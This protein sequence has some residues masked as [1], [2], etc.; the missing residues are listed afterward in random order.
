MMLLAPSDIHFVRDC[1]CPNFSGGSQVVI[2]VEI[3]KMQVVSKD[4]AWFALNS[5]SLHVLRELEKQGKCVRIEV[6]VVPLSKV[7]PRVQKG[8]VVTPSPAPPVS[9]GDNAEVSHETDPSRATKRG[10]Q[11]VP[12][13]TEEAHAT[14]ADVQGSS[15]S[16]ASDNDDDEESETEDDDGLACNVCDRTF[17]SSRLLALHQQRRRHFGCSVCDSLFPHLMAL[18]EHRE[19]LDHWSED[20]GDDEESRLSDDSA[21]SDSDGSQER[22]EE[23]ERLL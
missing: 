14:T 7:P 17:A 9:A 23:L 5:S 4:G 12:A 6:D 8:M 3:P 21:G 13:A 11:K 20:E 18:E 19:R 22:P 16:E 2:P 1:P 15:G 10:Y